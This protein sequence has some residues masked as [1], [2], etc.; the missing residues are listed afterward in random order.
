VDIPDRPGSLASLLALL[1]ESGANVLDVTHSRLG[2]TLALGRV[3]VELQLECR[4]NEHA[5]ALVGALGN[6]GFAA[7]LV[8]E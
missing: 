7:Q 5:N 4:S 6:A 8:T 1:G 3:L 2:P